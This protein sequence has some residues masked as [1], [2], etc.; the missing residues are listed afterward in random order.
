M[1]Y[2]WPR[3]GRLV[4]QLAVAFAL[5]GMWPSVSRGAPG[6]A[7]RLGGSEAQG[8]AT[9]AVT[10]LHHNP[11][12]LAAMRSSSAHVAFSV[13]ADQLWVRRNLI[14]AS[15]GAPLDDLAD[16]TSVLNPALG[17][18][19]GASLYTDPF[20]VGIGVYDLGSR[21]RL[22]SSD[23]LRYHLAPDPDVSDAGGLCLDARRS[24]CPP[25]GGNLDYQQDFTVAVAWN[26]GALQ[27][28]AG[29]HM[30]MVRTRFAFDNDTSLQ[31]ADDTGELPCNAREDPACAERVGFKGFT[32][33]IPREGGESAF[34]LALS[35]GVAYTLANDR[36]T[37]GARYRTFPVRRRGH[38]TLNGVGLVCRPD[39]TGDEDVPGVVDACG[40]A[41]AVDATLTQR[42]PQEVALGG[43]FVLGRAKLWRLDTNLYWL[44]LCV[45][46]ARPASCEDDGSQ[47]LTL[48]GL[49]ADAYVLPEF[50]RYRGLQDLFGID[51]YATYR[52]RSNVSLT[53]AGHMS[54]PAVRPA[55]LT[56]AH[57]D[58]WRVGATFG[59]TFRVRQSDFLLVPGYGL[60]TY[61]PTRVAT[62]EA[63]FD[64]T[65][66]TALEE[67]GLDIN[68]P[69]AAAVLEGRARP[70]NAGR[71]FGM[72]HTVSLTFRWAERG[73]RLE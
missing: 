68:A 22:Q 2:A 33:W 5:F 57:S 16:R 61:L 60:D 58:G 17:Y 41:D 18:F 40:T 35:F 63:L 36:V 51:A 24:K 73:G 37:L 44:D 15:S 53:V 66:A 6:Q 29:V 69:G 46:G 71:Y 30:P 39:A 45:G 14:D 65:A 3:P 67:S 32:N 27:L 64:P 50:P 26:G 1:G 59:A 23:T 19:V 9:R 21:Y 34:D 48:I 31:P 72:V 49:D 43:S 56:A 55:A 8:P 38:V 7:I 12:M 54:S 10:A 62:G 28:G 11:A 20:A 4:A 42:L 47:T 70:T 13:G 25:D 52:A